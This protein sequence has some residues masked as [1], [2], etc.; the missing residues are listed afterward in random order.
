MTTGTSLV[1]RIVRQHINE[2]RYCYEQELPR[3]PALAGR[4]LVQFVVA[5]T[6]RVMTSF[7]ESSTLADP[8]VG[9]CVTEAVRRWEF[10]KPEGGGLVQV[11]YP[12]QLQPAG[13]GS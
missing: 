5:G 1:R 7:V 11:S 6:G 3:H 9:M 13:G 8:R 2:V 12:F 10:P 4:L